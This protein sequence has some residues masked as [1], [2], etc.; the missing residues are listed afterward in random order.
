MGE[1]RSG[2][3]RNIEMGWVSLLSA[4][5]KATR[6]ASASHSVSDCREERFIQAKSAEHTTSAVSHVS[7]QFCE[8]RERSKGPTVQFLMVQD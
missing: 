2:L 5:E 8:S 6:Q 1:T 4:L 7:G 3:D